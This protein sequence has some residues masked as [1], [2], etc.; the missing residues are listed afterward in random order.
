MFGAV[1]IGGQSIGA[2]RDARRIESAQDN[3]IQ[4]DEDSNSIL[5]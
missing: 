1:E 4:I 5:D 2:R 3:F